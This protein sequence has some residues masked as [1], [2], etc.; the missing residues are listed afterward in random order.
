M[1]PIR[2][3]VL[4]VLTVTFFVKK[5]LSARDMPLI[6]SVINRVCALAS[7]TA[8]R[9]RNEKKKRKKKKEEG[10]GRATA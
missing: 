1:L 8:K 6:N 4:L 5:Y 10:E 9:M 3:C 2:I 7:K